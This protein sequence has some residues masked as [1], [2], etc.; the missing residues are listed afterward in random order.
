MGP[1]SILLGVALML[2][3]ALYVGRPFLRGKGEQQEALSA[4]EAL[5]AHKEALLD[6]IRTLDFELET[7]KMPEEEYQRQRAPLLQEAASVLKEL[8]DLAA[9]QPG[10]GATRHA[11][12]DVE[13]DIEAAIAAAR[14]TQTASDQAETPA[15]QDSELEI[16][17]AVRQ[18]RRTSSSNGVATKPRAQE[19]VSQTTGGRF[20]SKCGNPR[21]AGDKFCAYCGASFA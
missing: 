15:A 13:D 18:L 5:L 10:N 12:R 2:V 7:G 17:A 14:A 4:R 9:E 16:E 11:A 21:E 20:C 1:G 6:Q 19:P 8:D 3:V